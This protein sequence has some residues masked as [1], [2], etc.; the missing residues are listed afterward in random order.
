MSSFDPPQP[1]T[2]RADRRAVRQAYDAA[3]EPPNKPIAAIGDNRAIV[4][5]AGEQHL[6]LRGFYAV[7][8]SVLLAVQLA[9]ADG[10]FIAY[11]AWG[12]H[13]KLAE[14]LV[15]VWLGAAVVQVI[16]V[17][18]VVAKYLFS[19]IPAAEGVR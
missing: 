19:G 7:Y 10:I 1:A 11:A 9:V 14:P 2:T 17:V 3:L 5:R 16:G 12:V 18:L 8:L 15:G 13:W 4:L 6:R